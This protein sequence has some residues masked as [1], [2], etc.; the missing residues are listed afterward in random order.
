M[1]TAIQWDKE[2]GDG[3]AAGRAAGV[4]LRSLQILLP[5]TRAVVYVSAR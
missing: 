2:N 1:H 3:T 4:G 5:T